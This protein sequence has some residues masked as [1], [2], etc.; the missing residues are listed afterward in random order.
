MSSIELY[1]AHHKADLNSADSSDAHFLN[2]FIHL[3]ATMSLS[4]QNMCDVPISVAF[5]KK[6]KTQKT[7]LGDHS[8]TAEV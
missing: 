3:Y 5:G 1:W 8:W 7:Q 2:G 4:R 6:N